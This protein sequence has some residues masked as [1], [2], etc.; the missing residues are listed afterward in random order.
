MPSPHLKDTK[1]LSKLRSIVLDPEPRQVSPELEDDDDFVGGIEEVDIPPY[2]PP[3]GAPPPTVGAHGGNSSRPPVTIPQHTPVP[4]SDP[5]ELADL[6]ASLVSGD[7]VTVEESDWR[8]GAVWTTVLGSLLKR[9]FVATATHSDG[10]YKITV[11]R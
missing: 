2:R 7:A 9:G 6:M 8:G 5:T 1:P 11:K 3:T 10:T 4:V